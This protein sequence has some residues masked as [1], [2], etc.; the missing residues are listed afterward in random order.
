[1]K[2]VGFYY[3]DFCRIESFQELSGMAPH[4]YTSPESQLSPMPVQ[5][6]EKRAYQYEDV[7]KDERLN[8]AIATDQVRIFSL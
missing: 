1:M 5:G 2:A 3:L 4:Y 8:E 7:S 6:D